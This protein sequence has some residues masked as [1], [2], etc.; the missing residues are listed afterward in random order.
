MPKRAVNSVVR[1]VA[2]TTIFV[3]ASFGNSHRN[4]N[5]INLILDRFNFCSEQ[6]ALISC[7]QVGVSSF[8]HQ[9]ALHFHYQETF[10]VEISRLRNSLTSDKWRRSLSEKSTRLKSLIF[11]FRKHFASEFIICHARH[12]LSADC[13]VLV[14]I[15]DLRTQ[16][17]SIFSR[18]N[19]CFLPFDFIAAVLFLV[20]SGF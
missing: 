14:I 9:Y 4:W 13:W 16:R 1:S 3:S 11:F 10:R 5:Q 19:F 2:L 18:T 20:R 6:A 15:I 12:W 8:L 7:D 17:G